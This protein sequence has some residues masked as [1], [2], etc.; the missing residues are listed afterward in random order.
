MPQDTDPSQRNEQ[1]GR[2]FHRSAG[3]HARITDTAGIPA[4]ESMITGRDAY[5]DEWC[6][7]AAWSRR[8]RI[9][10]EYPGSFARHSSVPSPA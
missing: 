5:A 8:R 3:N 6:D 9:L 4:S 10:P 2:D 1:N 7:D